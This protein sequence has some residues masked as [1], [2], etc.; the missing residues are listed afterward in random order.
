M[1]KEKPGFGEMYDELEKYEKNGVCILMDGYSVSPMQVVKAHMA[2]EH[3]SYMRDYE[4]DEEGR[5]EAISFI[6]INKNRRRRRYYRP[7]DPL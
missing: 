5:L 6:N 1:K 7:Y 3:V 4:V 2:R